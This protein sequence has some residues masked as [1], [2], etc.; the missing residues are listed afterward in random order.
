MNNSENIKLKEQNFESPQCNIPKEKIIDRIIENGY[1]T[2]YPIFI[3]ISIFVCFIANG[4]VTNIFNLIIIPTKKYF[5][6]SDF[7]TETMAGILFIGLAIGSG[8]ASFLSEKYGRAKIIKLFSGVMCITYLISTIIFNLFIFLLSRIILGLSV[9]IIEPLIFNT[10]GEYLPSNFRG[11]LL[12]NSWFFYTLAVFLDNVIAL[13]IMP[14][15]ESEHLQRYLLVLNFFFILNYVINHFILNDSPR[16]LI[17]KSMQGKNFYE[18]ESK[19]NEAVKILNNMNRTP[20]SKIEEE[21]LISELYNSSSNK[22]KTNSSFKELFSQKYLKTTYIGIFIFFVYS[23][24]YFGFYIISTLTLEILNKKENEKISE[25]ENKNS[26]KDIIKNQI[27]I[28]F[29]DLL[30]S[31]VGGCLAEIKSI[32]R[33]GV[34]WIFMLLSAITLIP[35]CFSVTLFNIFFT[36]S[37]TFSAIYGAML[38][39]Y[40]SEIFPTK[41][42][43]ISSSFFLTSHR[44]SGF[45]SQFLFLAL[46]KINYKL[47][48]FFGSLLNIIGVMTIFMLPY[49][50]IGKP[51]DYEE[52]VEQRDNNQIEF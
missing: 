32:G 43:D 47:P 12:M 30:G 22:T 20:L 41:L 46:F 24:G 34:I 48:F 36:V 7:I 5:K 39:T 17:I 25:I 45:I 23:C 29:F 51:L 40:I 8:L 4:L 21:K 18:R 28:A 27:Y 1:F 13:K 26:N 10:F 31:F 15:L 44:I 16:N 11:F 37:I 14:Y 19:I 6:A 3:T 42:R 38:I 33:K 35:S 49:E 2:K 9:G 52:V 50:S